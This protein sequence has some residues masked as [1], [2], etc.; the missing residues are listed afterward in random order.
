MKKQPFYSFKTKL[1]LSYL[2]LICLPL[3]I[4][5]G[6]SFIASRNALYEQMTREHRSHLAD[7]EYQITFKIQEYIELGDLIRYDE[8]ILRILENDYRDAINLRRDLVNYLDPFF[9]RTYLL[10]PGLKAIKIYT[11]STVPQYDDYINH[12]EKMHELEWLPEGSTEG[13]FVDGTYVY[14][15]QQFFNYMNYDDE[16]YLVLT[17]DKQSLLTN[18]NGI[19]NEAI[20]IMDN[21]TNI[22]YQSE[23]NQLTEAFLAGID[24][25]GYQVLKERVELVDWYIYAI[26]EKN[27]DSIQLMSIIKIM[28]TIIMACLG[29]LFI[30]AMYLTNTL[31]GP[32]KDLVRVMK[33]VGEGDFKV[34][35]ESCSHDEIGYMTYEFNHMIT[36]IN[37]LFE[38]VYKANIIKKEAQLKA[39]QAQ[40][41]PHFLY[42]TL[43]MINWKAILNHQDEI[44]KSVTLLSKFYETALNKGNS[45]I[46]V[47]DEVENMKAYIELQLI[48]HSYAFSVVYDIDDSVYQYHMLNLVLQPFVENAIE[49]GV[50][51]LEDLEEGLIRCKAYSTKNNLIFIIEDNGVG[52]QSNQLVNLVNEKNEHYGINNVQER[53]QLQFG[54]KYG[55]ELHNRE[56]DDGN[57]VRVIITLPLYKLTEDNE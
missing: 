43:S 28:L 23:H 14:F 40:I 36:K 7:I 4:L 24:N 57:G 54:E 35:I 13:W 41:N 2:L 26:V 52:I 16:N 6:Y 32:I 47:Y 56:K 15:V 38:Q 3:I 25:K 5:G 55:V 20:I 44:S 21:M 51:Q 53:I 10:K 34:Q 29:L 30:L 46:S 31:F 50:R 11:S 33:N 42:N 9:K 39:L 8:N 22:T 37:D 19:R 1:I 49:H 17:I 48:M 45:I 12:L 18:I 27:I